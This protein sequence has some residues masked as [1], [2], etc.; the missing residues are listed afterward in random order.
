MDSKSYCNFM[1]RLSIYDSQH[2]QLTR[3][4]GGDPIVTFHVYPETPTQFTCS[5]DLPL[6]PFTSEELITENFYTDPCNFP[7]QV[8]QANYGRGDYSYGPAFIRKRNERERQRVKCVNEGYAK[9]R[10]HLPEEYLEKR[11]SKVETLR[12]AIKYI[13]YLQSVLYS[14]SAV[15]EKNNL[16]LGH[17][18]KAITREIQF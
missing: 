8:A 4:F 6:L 17:T 16:E 15:T 9:L 1:D 10:R 2:V 11:L 7:Y 14:D 3:P 5:E 18:S 12:A 13:H